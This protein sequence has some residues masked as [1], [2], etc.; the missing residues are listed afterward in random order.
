VDR[1]WPLVEVGLQRLE[2]AWRDFRRS[3]EPVLG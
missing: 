1:P 3:A 2:L